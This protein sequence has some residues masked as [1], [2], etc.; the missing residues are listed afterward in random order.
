MAAP[1]NDPLIPLDGE[2]EVPDFGDW[3]DLAAEGELVGTYEGSHE[4]GF[5]PVHDFVTPDGERVSLPGWTMLTRKLT[6]LEGHAVRVV[7]RGELEPSK[8]GQQ[9]ARAVSV[10]DRGIA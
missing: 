5:G 9:G 7:Y 2:E 10:F 4:G 3:Y 1:K 6:G 8:K